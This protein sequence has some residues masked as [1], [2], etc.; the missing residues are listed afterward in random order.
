MPNISLKF[1]NDN[2]PIFSFQTNFANFQQFSNVSLKAL[3]NFFAKQIICFLPKIVRVQNPPIFSF[4]KIFCQI[5]NSSQFSYVTKC[6]FSA[7]TNFFAKPSNF[8]FFF[9][10]APKPFRHPRSSGIPRIS[11]HQF[12]CSKKNFQALSMLSTFQHFCYVT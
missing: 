3:T 1:I 11:R 5:D 9:I 4:R 2:L 7:S 6:K 12:A 8:R 10:L